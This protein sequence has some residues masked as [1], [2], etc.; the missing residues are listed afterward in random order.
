M[1][2][3]KIIQRTNELL[4][5]ETLSYLELVPFFDHVIDDIN[6]QLNT[7]FLAFSDLPNE[8]TEYNLFPDRYLRSVLCVGA[9]MYFYMTD[10]EGGQAPPGYERKYQEGMFYMLR[11]YIHMVPELWKAVDTAGTVAFD[12]QGADHIDYGVIQGDFQP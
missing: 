12:L 4:A 10:E 5:G 2:L 3:S 11:D 1:L 8:T 7:V 9:A 6:Q